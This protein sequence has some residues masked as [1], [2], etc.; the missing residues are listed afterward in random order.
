MSYLTTDAKVYVFS[1]DSKYFPLKV[2]KGLD[3]VIVNK[4]RGLSPLN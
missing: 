2:V 4:K 3:G 1:R